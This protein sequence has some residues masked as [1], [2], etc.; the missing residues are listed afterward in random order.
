[1][2]STSLHQRKPSISKDPTPEQVDT[3]RLPYLVNPSASPAIV[4]L[5]SLTSP[6][7]QNERS[8]SYTPI[9][10]WDGL[11]HALSESSLRLHQLYLE[12]KVLI[13]SFPIFN[14]I[15]FVA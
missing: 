12:F 3:L 11:S 6:G 15:L 5:L 2:N 9:P 13:Y 14:V 10:C 1:M 4:R 8:I 7:I